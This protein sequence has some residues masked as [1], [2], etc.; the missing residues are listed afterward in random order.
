MRTNPYTTL[1]H[2][3]K[4][5]TLPLT[6]FERLVRLDQKNRLTRGDIAKRYGVSRS[7]LVRKPWLVPNCDI[8]TKGVRSMQWTREEVEEWERIPEKERIA[9]YER[10][11]ERA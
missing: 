10:A 8:K 11:K 6:E 4:Y 2:G 7:M 1:V 3:I 9:L 5:V